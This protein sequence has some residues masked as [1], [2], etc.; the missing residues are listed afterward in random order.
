MNSEEVKVLVST[1][2]DYVSGAQY[3][4][5]HIAE[6][7]QALRDQIHVD[8]SATI[9]EANRARHTEEH[10]YGQASPTGITRDAPS[11]DEGMSTERLIIKRLL[12]LAQ[13]PTSVE[14]LVRGAVW[15]GDTELRSSAIAAVRAITQ[16]RLDDE[17]PF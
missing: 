11:Y 13:L 12:P 5:A 9:N 15:D 17:I 4:P 6:M 1:L 3:L 7:M 2:N 10:A 14:D 16:H 8:S